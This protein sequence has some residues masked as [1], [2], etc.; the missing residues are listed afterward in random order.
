MFCIGRNF[1]DHLVPAFLPLAGPPFIRPGCSEPHST[2]F[3]CCQ[4]WSKMP[5]MGKMSTN[6][7]VWWL[8]REKRLTIIPLHPTVS[9]FQKSR[10]STLIHIVYA[11]A[12]QLQW[13]VS[14][15]VTTAY[16]SASSLGMW[17]RPNIAGE[18]KVVRMWDDSWSCWLL[19]T[20]EGCQVWKALCP[21]HYV[22]MGYNMGSSQRNC[23]IQLLQQEASISINTH[24]W[25]KLRLLCIQSLDVLP[26]LHIGFFPYVS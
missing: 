9:P 23:L 2:W 3:E 25:T 1:K 24:F 15:F 22:F 26:P 17:Q 5:T 18:E 4:E 16:F 8:D 21:Q 13:L 10:N 7:E 11:T 20:S 14:T 12:V 19:Y 6:A